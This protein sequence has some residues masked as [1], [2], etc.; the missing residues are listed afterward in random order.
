ML[1]FELLRGRDYGDLRFARLRD[2]NRGAPRP[3]VYL[4]AKRSLMR[5]QK[6]TTSIRS[7]KLHIHTK[8]MSAQ[9]GA[10]IVVEG[11]D[12]S[13]KTTQ[14]QKLVEALSKDG[15]K[16]KALRFPGELYHLQDR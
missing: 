5:L 1:W 3:G 16:V 7:N 8:I 15:H 11:L 14:V 12:R 2:V 6:A 9:R 4:E 13:G 10:F